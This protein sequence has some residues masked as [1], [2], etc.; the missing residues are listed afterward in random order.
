[1]YHRT[2]AGTPPRLDGRTI[3]YVG[4]T[5]QHGDV[6]ASPFSFL[7]DSVPFEVLL[8]SMLKKERNNFLGCIFM[9]W[10]CS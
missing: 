5:Q 6:P 8:L 2:T 3:N 4:L 10:L 7:N 9:L 1:M